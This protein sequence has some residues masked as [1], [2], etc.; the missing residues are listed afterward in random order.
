MTKPIKTLIRQEEV[1][2]W[3]NEGKPRK[4]ILKLISTTY[5]V[6]ERRAAE[7][8]YD[9]LKEMAPDTTMFDAYRQNV[10]QQNL[11]RLESIINSSINGNFN[12]K[13]VALKAIDTINKLIHAYGDQGVVINKNK[14]GDEQIIIK[15]GE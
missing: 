10:I 12:E 5:N 3:I 2:N 1:S 4:E 7:L 8:Y 11:D 6:N 13:N 14:D 15:F 9:T